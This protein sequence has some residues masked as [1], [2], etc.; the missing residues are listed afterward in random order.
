MDSLVER[1]DKILSR[2]EAFQPPE[3]VVRILLDCRATLS[4]PL[5][6][7]VAN[8]TEFLRLLAESRNPPIGEALLLSADL[9]ERLE[10]IRAMS[11]QEE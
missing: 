9:L 4:A 1:I 7:E 11:E 3:Y 8:S 10:R 5:S 2:T 6:D